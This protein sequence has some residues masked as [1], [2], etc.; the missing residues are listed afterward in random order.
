VRVAPE[1]ILKRFDTPDEPYESVHVLGA[2]TC[3]K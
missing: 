3:A 1:V 2:E